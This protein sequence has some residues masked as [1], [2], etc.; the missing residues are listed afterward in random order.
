MGQ[1]KENNICILGTPEGEE[2]EKVPEKIFEAIVAEKF[3][4]WGR[5][6]HLGP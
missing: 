1:H 3:P 6:R 4:I 5:N 2:R